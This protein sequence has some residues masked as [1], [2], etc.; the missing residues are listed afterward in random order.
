[1][2]GSCR[3]RGINPQ[4]YLTDVLSRLPSITINRIGELTPANWKPPPTD[5][6]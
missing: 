1:M 3:R 2:I 5:T 6:S 4:D